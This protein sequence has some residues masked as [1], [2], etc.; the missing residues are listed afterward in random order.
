MPKEDEFS[1]DTV[2]EELKSV[3]SDVIIGDFTFKELSYE[4]QRKITS[5][6]NSL[7]EIIAST[8]NLLNEYIAKNVV[9][10]N[11][12]ANISNTVTLDIRPFLLNVLRTI[13]IGKEIREDG[14]E[15]EFYSVQESDL[16]ST[17]KPEV[18]K[19]D[20]FELVIQVPTLKEDT[21][22]NT[23]LM[24]ALSQYRNKQARTMTEMEAGAINEIYTFYENMKYIKSFTI[25]KSTYEFIDL[26]TH[27]K[28][29]VLN[30]FPQQIISAINRYRKQ[31]DNLVEKAFTATCNSDG[32]T[33]VVDQE[34]QLFAQIED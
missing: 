31:V 10:T 7:V 26:T 14:K 16:K 29:K 30:Q 5:S 3:Q 28:V 13:S 8:K 15:Y 20:T 27:D 32:S 2:L 25:G 17:L 18:F 22:Y 33:M 9:Y 1:L 12:M 21:I 34:I 23:I 19:R 4:Q 11:D 24:G 6:T